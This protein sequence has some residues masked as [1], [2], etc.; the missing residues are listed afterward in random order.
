[1]KNSLAPGHGPNKQLWTP[2]PR[3]R[4]DRLRGSDEI[5]TFYETVNI[6]VL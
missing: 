2:V 1:M 6:H 3:L 5:L 4:G